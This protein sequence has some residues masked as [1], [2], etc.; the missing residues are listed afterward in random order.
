[1]IESPHAQDAK[2]SQELSH[3]R[4][5]IA[6]PR[7]QIADD[8]PVDAGAGRALGEGA[9]DAGDRFDVTLDVRLDAERHVVEPARRELS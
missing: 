5:E 8:L 2:R 4:R 7:R 9:L 6:E 3:R 1:M